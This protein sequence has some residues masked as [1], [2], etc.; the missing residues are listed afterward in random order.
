MKFRSIFLLFFLFNS[1]MSSNMTY[2]K[3]SFTPYSSKGFALIYNED[4][5]NNKLISHKL[6]NSQ[7]QIAHNKLKK[8][9][10][11]TLTNISNKKTLT[12]N[13]SKNINYPNFYKVLI[14]QKVADELEIDA[15]L[16]FVDLQ[17]RAKNQSFI[18]KKGTTFPEEKYVSEK[19]PITKVKIDSINSNVIK[20][21]SKPNKK[22][23]IILG[24]FYSE[25][26]ANELKSFLLNDYVKDG[27]LK[28]KKLQKNKFRLFAGPYLSISTLKNDY[29][30]LQKYGFEDLDIEQYD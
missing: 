5:F 17:Q 12:L 4:D 30:E 25:E 10:I 20:N 19:A 23:S 13:V 14:T 18:A 3:N 21:Q 27:P 28:V 11:V 16:P 26:S 15:N 8:N 2:K 6:D 24:D 22:F 7:L 1:C 9:S 29:F